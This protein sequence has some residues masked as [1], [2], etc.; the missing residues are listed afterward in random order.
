MVATSPNLIQIKR[1]QNTAAP[2]SLANGELAW[3]ASSNALFIGNYGIVTQIASG[4]TPGVLTANQALVANSTG[5]INSVKA[6][7]V[8]ITG[9]LTANGSSGSAGQMLF[10][11][12]TGKAYWNSLDTSIPA[13]YVQNTDS[14]T[15]SGN[16]TFSGSKTIF[17]GAN[18][19]VTTGVISGNGMYITGVDA[20]LLN[21][22]SAATI[23]STA[24][25]YADTAFA[26]AS[27]KADNAFANAISQSKTYVDAQTFDLSTRTSGN[28]V[29]TITAGNGIDT[30]SASSHGSTPTITV[31]AGTGVTVSG[32]GVSIGQSV[33]TTDNV[34]FNDV[35]INGNTAL[36]SDSTDR[37]HFNGKVDTTILPSA[38]NS[39]DLGSAS[40]AWN[41]VY[42]KEVSI[43]N[44]HL[45]GTNAII[46][47]AGGLTVNTNLIANVATIYH[48]LYLGGDL[49]ITGNAVYSNVESY[50]V[51][52]PLIQLGS[53]N[54]LTDLIDIGFFGNY[55][56]DGNAAHHKHTG[57]FR[58][59]SDGV[60]KIFYNLDTNPELTNYIDTGDASY[61]QGT[62]QAWLNSG[63]FVSNA[64]GVSIIGTNTYKV[65][66]TA[67]TIASNTLTLNV[68]L[69]TGSGGTG[70]NT[71]SAGD[72]LTGTG[73][74]SLTTLGIGTQGQVLQV[75]AGGT[76][77]IYGGLD[78]G[79]F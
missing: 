33:G 48:D 45:T 51:T 76:S 10:S 57:F 39:Y 14:R 28:Y 77:L 34:T 25:G 15:L 26:N 50:S 52:D 74:G 54:T 9:M 13:T 11:D 46:T 49:H 3:S 30:L 53:N 41:T 35:T 43:G 68:A 67:N 65:E 27:I 75:A 63:A 20:N 4:Q 2:G 62:L 21:G 18:V 32:S 42:A 16:L 8:T 55:G 78:G 44:V 37:V 19:N 1:A 7:N 23:L 31:K 79:T 56:T 36:G 24:S 17:T 38:I 6:G 40:L 60:Y 5:F 71:Y 22:S 29:A 61:R 72:L 73:G 58:D 69:A 64:T 47:V 59:S 12:G 66:I 70:Y